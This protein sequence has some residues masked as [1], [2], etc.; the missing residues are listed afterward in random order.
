[1]DEIHQAG[2]PEEAAR[3]GRAAQRTRP[4][5]VRPDWETVKLFIML[6]ALQAK[7]GRPS[8]RHSREAPRSAILNGLNETPSATRKCSG[9]RWS[10]ASSS[11]PAR[12]ARGRGTE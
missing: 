4:H 7:V 9:V 11:A 2:S 5:L 6:A 8:V 10:K 3:L 1:M 12:K